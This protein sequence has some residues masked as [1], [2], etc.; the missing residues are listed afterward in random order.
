MGR[1]KRMAEENQIGDYQVTHVITK[2]N[3]WQAICYHQGETFY[4]KKGLPFVY[5][6]RGGELFVDRRSK[7]I[8]RSTFEKAFEKL[9]MSEQGTAEGKAIAGPK[10]LNVYGAP[11]VWAVF[12]GIGVVSERLPIIH[13]QPTSKVL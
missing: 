11:Y 13:C 9:R 5:T 12:M 6:V 8:T 10:A 3:L 2:E 4:T 1:K 7:S